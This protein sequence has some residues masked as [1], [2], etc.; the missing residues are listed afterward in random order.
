MLIDRLDSGISSMAFSGKAYNP[1]MR[2]EEFKIFGDLNDVSQGCLRT[3]SAAMNLAYVASGKFKL[4]LGKANKLWDV[5]AGLL[6]AKEAGADLN[7]N[8][9]DKENF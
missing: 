8:I 5:A 2:H 7:Y 6:I 1:D 3:G 4:A 9:T